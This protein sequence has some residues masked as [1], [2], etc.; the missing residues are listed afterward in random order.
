MDCLLPGE[1][2]FSLKR[3]QQYSWGLQS[4]IWAN[5]KTLQ[6]KKEMNLG[7]ATTQ[8]NWKGLVGA[9]ETA[10]P[11]MNRRNVVK[12]SGSKLF[13]SN[14][15]DWLPPI[16]KMVASSHYIWRC[17]GWWEEMDSEAGGWRKR[18]KLLYWKQLRKARTS[19]N[20][21]NKPG[22]TKRNQELSNLT[23]EKNI[24]QTSNN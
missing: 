2:L 24:N 17:H 22:W 9:Q 14:V 13:Y 4:C 16:Q 23:E 6:L 5:R 19:W 15:R 11:Q 1:S 3:T 8:S 21:K 12:K 7:T 20:T 10:Q 18:T